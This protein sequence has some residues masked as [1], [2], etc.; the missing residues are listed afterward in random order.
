MVDPHHRAVMA[1]QHDLLAAHAEHLA[2]DVLR[3]V[4]GEERRERR[5]VGRRHLL[6]LLDARLLRGRRRGNR[7]DHPRPRE[8]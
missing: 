3:V 4:G 2:A 8:R 5:D 1:E 7:A 6:D